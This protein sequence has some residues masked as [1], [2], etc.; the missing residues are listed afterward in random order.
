MT[1][2]KHGLVQSAYAY[3]GFDSDDLRDMDKLADRDRGD[4]WN[5]SLKF[6]LSLQHLDKSEAKS[7]QIR[8]A[9]KIKDQVEDL[10]RKGKI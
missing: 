8:W 2:V 1:R 7:G 3:M 5:R 10:R 9:V 6:I 4:Y